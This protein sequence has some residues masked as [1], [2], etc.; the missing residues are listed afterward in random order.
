MEAV[1]FICKNNG[2][3]VEYSDEERS[4][5]ERVEI[6]HKESLLIIL[7]HLQ[8]FFV[9]N[10]RVAM[11]DESRVAREYSYGRCPEEFCSIAG[12]GCSCI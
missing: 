2:I 11:T 5:E 7:D 8:R 9:E 4:E 6:K 3:P 12:I 1:T 10:L